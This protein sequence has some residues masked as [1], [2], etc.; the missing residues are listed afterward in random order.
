[1]DLGELEHR[2][3]ILEDVEAIKKLKARYCLA[4]DV[5][6]EEGFVSLF[7][8][9]AVWDGGRFGRYEGRAAIQNFFRSIPEILS[10]A[11]HYVMN[12][13]IEVQGE[14]ATGRWYLLEPCT[15]VEGNRAVWGT[16]QYDEVYVKKGGEW[17]FQQI[18]L[19]PVF[20]SPYDQGWVRRRFVQD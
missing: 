2:L 4:V 14:Q 11:V 17:K 7:T 8:E 13:V 18:K 12:P 20:W 10:F 6:E 16:A 15:M 5:R 3:Q 1:M 19:I 9:D